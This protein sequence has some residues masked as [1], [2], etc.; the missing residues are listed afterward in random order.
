[1]S[2]SLLVN[3]LGPDKT[4]VQQRTFCGRSLFV[5][6]T[7]EQRRLKNGDLPRSVP[8]VPGQCLDVHQ[9]AVQVHAA[10]LCNEAYV[11]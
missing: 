8:P 5:L 9:E 3:E 10:T 6:V 2:Q 4:L 11:R 7:H 1:M